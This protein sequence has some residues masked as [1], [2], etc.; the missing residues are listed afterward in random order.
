MSEKTFFLK[1]KKLFNKQCA[2]PLGTHE[3]INVL[4]YTS[5]PTSLWEVKI[6]SLQL[7]L[8][9]EISLKNTVVSNLAVHIHH[10]KR[11]K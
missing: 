6:D 11:L 1:K 8:R 4:Y 3:G 2:S 5:L 9:P 7:W 10:S